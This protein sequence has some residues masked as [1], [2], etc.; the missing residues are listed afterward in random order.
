VPAIG[1]WL[2]LTTVVFVCVLKE[3]IMALRASR[4]K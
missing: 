3:A 2:M 1:L 4:V